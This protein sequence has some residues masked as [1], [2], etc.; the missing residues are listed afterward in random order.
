VNRRVAIKA[1]DITDVLRLT[2]TLNSHRTGIT[3]AE[4]SACSLRAGGAM[5]LMYGRTDMNDICMMERWHI[6][7]MMRYLNIQ[8]AP[9]LKNMLLQCSIMQT[10]PSSLTRRSPSS[11][12]TTTNVIAHNNTNPSASALSSHP[13]NKAH[14]INTRGAPPS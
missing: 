1:K 8:A 4:V 6:D 7:A 13:A 11:T 2:M 12:C 14:G 10:T 3:A 9:I 5:A